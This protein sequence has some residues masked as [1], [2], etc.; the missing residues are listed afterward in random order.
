MN[1]FPPRLR[2]F[3]LGLLCALALGAAS[4]GPAAPAER[5]FDLFEPLRST[6]AALSPDGKYLAYSLRER[7]NLSVVTVAVDEPTKVL[8]KMNLGNDE[9]ATPML[10][11]NVENT[12]LE[13]R[14]M[15]WVTPTRLAIATN[16]IGVT[17]SAGGGWR[18]VS[19][20]IF[21]VDVDGRNPRTLLTPRG[22]RFTMP[23][24]MPPPIERLAEQ[25]AHNHRFRPHT[26][27]TDINV[28]ANVFDFSKDDP[29]K[30]ILQAQHRTK[31]RTYALNVLTGKL[32]LLEEDV[33]EGGLVPFFDRQ[34]N[35]RGGVHGTLNRQPPFHYVLQKNQTLSLGRWRRIDELAQSAGISGFS[36]SPENY[37]GE[38]SI[39]VGFDE[40]P[41]ILYYASNVGR[42]TYGLYALDVKSGQRTSFSFEDPAFDVI[43]LPRSNLPENGMLV[44]DRFTREL[45]GIRY[46][47]LVKTT[48]WLRPELQATQ[49]ELE[50]L[51]SGRNVEI[52]QWDKTHSR[53][54]VLV[55]GV[56]DPGSYVVYEPGALKAF[57][58]VRRAAWC[59][60]R[61]THRTMG[62]SFA[63]PDGRTLNGLLTFPN[64]ARFQ[65]VPVVVRCP[66]E[67]WQRA[68]LTFQS[69]T[70]ALAD[71]GFAV[72]QIDS[73][74]AWG[75]GIKHR[76]AIRNGYEQLIVEDIVT[77]L[78]ELAKTYRINPQ[79][80][81][82][83]GEGYGGH[84]ALRGLQLHP[85]KFRCAVAIDAPLDLANWMENDRWTKRSTLLEL[86]RSYYGDRD[87]LKQTPLISQ[88][89][90]ITK[91]V[92]LL[93][94]PGR[95]GGP[96]SY[97]Y[98]ETLQLARALR[99]HGVPVEVNEIRKETR[100]AG[101]Y[102][103][104]SSEEKSHLVELDEEFVQNL[105]HSQAAVYRQIEYFLNSYI[106]EYDVRLGPMVEVPETRR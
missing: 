47:A 22:I 19:G 31:Y 57:D 32:S 33:G 8:A 58:I 6:S 45:V 21:G 48:H 7:E 40:N 38:R 72:V 75:Y 67:P 88:P 104:R 9:S 5:F 74:G 103:L 98:L 82:L 55:H 25:V 26:G 76:S 44:Y 42:N 81:A 79:R 24:L 27:F 77:V 69:E 35:F 56:A 60:S 13:I 16:R 85:E 62:F 86:T 49:D 105:P 30:I 46:D 100:D 36:V 97:I 43:G 78:H 66:P 90:K 54:L 80:V 4:P 23:D 84:V 52:Q 10:T 70:T 17:F 101:V 89:E 53:Y 87:H 93:A 65:T 34:G 64:L 92:C 61:P 37:L 59:D 102:D 51:F 71:M 15:Q 1:P 94:F 20:V 68:P 95:D 63:A 96:R 14:W 29:N 2:F 12:P 3:G 39:P 83:L 18:S 50:K 99:R 73:A 11:N 91:P 28:G 106:Y 41:D